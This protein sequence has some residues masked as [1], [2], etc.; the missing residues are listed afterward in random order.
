MHF[1]SAHEHFRGEIQ[2]RSEQFVAETIAELRLVDWGKSGN[3]YHLLWFNEVHTTIGGFVPSNL[4]FSR[5]MSP[6][7]SSEREIFWLLTIPYDVTCCARSRQAEQFIPE[8]GQQALSS[9]TSKPIVCKSTTALTY[10]SKEL[11]PDSGDSRRYD[12]H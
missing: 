8:L 2:E 7:A 9:A 6:E 10:R 1:T 5:R 4:M 12:A 11:M 3:L